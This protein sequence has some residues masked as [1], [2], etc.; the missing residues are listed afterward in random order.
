MALLLGADEGLLAGV[1][2]AEMVLKVIATFEWSTFSGTLEPFTNVSTPLLPFVEHF[3]QLNVLSE[4]AS[5][6]CQRNK[7]LTALFPS[8]E[9]CLNI[10]FPIKELNP[11]QL[12]TVSRRRKALK[13]GG[14]NLLLFPFGFQSSL[15]RGS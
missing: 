1:L 13:S 6:L 11:S 2:I 7:H 3:L 4:V 5:K 15:E 10:G 8:T 9:K 14:E 12:L